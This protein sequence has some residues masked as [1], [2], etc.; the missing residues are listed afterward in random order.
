MKNN[1]R[2]LFGVLFCF[3]LLSCCGSNEFVLQQK[4]VHPL[5]LMTFFPSVVDGS[6]A[7]TVNLSMVHF[8]QTVVSDSSDPTYS[9]VHGCWY[10]SY[11]SPADYVDYKKIGYLDNRSVVLL[12]RHVSNTYRQTQVFVLKMCNKTLYKKRQLDPGDL[13]CNRI[14]IRNNRVTIDSSGSM[15]PSL[16]PKK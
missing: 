4:P 15:K 14:L 10:R 9:T 13:T 5:S 7:E 2:L 11:E 3:Q 1:S 6:S 16:Y 8:A 12:A